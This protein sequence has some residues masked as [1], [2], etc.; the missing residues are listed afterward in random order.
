MGTITLTKIFEDILCNAA[1]KKHHINI[2]FYFTFDV[3]ALG[4]IY[5]KPIA[6]HSIYSGAELFFIG[7]SIAESFFTKIVA[8]INHVKHILML[9]HMAIFHHHTIP[10]GFG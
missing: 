8:V 2:L 6:L 1:A 10:A 3:A 7:N 4:Q 9:E 5:T